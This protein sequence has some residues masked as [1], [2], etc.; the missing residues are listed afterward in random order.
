MQDLLTDP[1]TLTLSERMRWRERHRRDQLQ[2]LPRLVR[3]VEPPQPDDSFP[4]FLLATPAFAELR[5]AIGDARDAREL[6]TATA[7]TLQRFVD[8]YRT[9]QNE[10]RDPSWS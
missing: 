9:W 3:L 5:A 10:L 8:H 6:D 1:W 2:W 4:A 7:D